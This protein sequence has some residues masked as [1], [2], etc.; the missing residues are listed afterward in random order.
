MQEAANWFSDF[1]ISLWETL[2][3][4]WDVVVTITAQPVRFAAAA[5]GY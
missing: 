2:C 5:A 4:L 3:A 1:L